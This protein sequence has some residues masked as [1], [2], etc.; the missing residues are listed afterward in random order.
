MGK[1]PGK[2]WGGTWLAEREATLKARGFRELTDEPHTFGF[3]RLSLF[4]AP[5]DLGDRLHKSQSILRS[6]LLLISSK[7]L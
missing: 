3:F 7:H 6:V 1:K 4:P 5:S 2:G